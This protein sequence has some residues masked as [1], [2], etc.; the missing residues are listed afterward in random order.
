[1]SHSSIRGAASC[2]SLFPL[3]F[4]DSEIAKNM[5]LQKDKL[6]Y[7]IVYGLAPY[8]AGVL[9]ALISSSDFIVLGF[10]ESF[11][12]VSNK[13]QMDL[14]IRF[15]NTNENR[16]HVRFVTSVFLH[17]T[18]AED[19]L[20]GIKTCIKE[21]NLQKI[22]QLSMDGPNVNF[23]VQ[24][25]LN[26]ELKSYPGCSQLLDLGSCGLHTVHNALKAG[27]K[28]TGWELIPFF[29]AVSNLFKQAPKRRGEYTKLT[30]SA[31]F[32]MTVCSVR[33][34]ENSKV[35]RRVRE[36]LPHLKTYVESTKGTKQEPTCA[37]YNVVYQ[38]IQDKL[39]LAKIAFF[40]SLCDVVE[41]FLLL[42]QSEQP[43]APFLYDKLMVILRTLMEK[44][45]KEE[46]IEKSL[47]TR[48]MFC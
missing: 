36:M 18:T 29:R 23:K 4:T 10:D 20:K 17:N 32:P 24:R 2:C 44:I 38:H 19:L 28:E 11:N 41:P 22:V 3:M 33:W 35:A 27:I 25:L 9:D 37:S 12:K 13:Q 6:S 1:M 34:V 39:M 43:L 30:G 14:G 8:F 40:E 16:V 46:V 15:W 21:T 5:K 26:E 31:I 48:L 45:V 42:F 47:F 7:M